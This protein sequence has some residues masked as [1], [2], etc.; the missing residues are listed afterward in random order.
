MSA[1]RATPHSKEMVSQEDVKMVN[2]VT[3]SFSYYVY[4][5]YCI[6]AT[7]FTILNKVNMQAFS[8]CSLCV[9]IRLLTAY[10]VLL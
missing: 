8:L 9:A 7:P 3:I 10:Y 5:L 6:V 2:L 1:T 4:L